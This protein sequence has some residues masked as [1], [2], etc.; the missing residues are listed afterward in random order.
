MDVPPLSQFLSDPSTDDRSNDWSEK[1][2]KGVDSLQTAHPNQEKRVAY[3]Y[4][5]QHGNQHRPSQAV[6]LST[7]HRQ[8][9]LF[10]HEQVRKRASADRERCGA[11]QTAE[12][13]EDGHLGRRLGK[14]AGDVPDCRACEG[15]EEK[16]KKKRGGRSQFRRNE[17][18][19]EGREGRASRSRTNKKQIRTLQHKFPSKHFAEWAQKEGSEGVREYEYGEHDRLLYAGRHVEFGRDE[20]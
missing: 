15:G 19:K 2:C 10:R 13:P 8:P 11:A 16:K 5:F 14:A 3:Q 20:R 1:W 9:P 7:N 6:V 4:H 17:A 18:G 12:E